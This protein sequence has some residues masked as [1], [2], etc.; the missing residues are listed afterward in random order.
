MLSE[1]KMSKKHK[2]DQNFLSRIIDTVDV[3]VIVINQQ[4]NIVLVNKACERFFGYTR[5]ELIR[6][7]VW[8][9]LLQSQEQAT[10][11]EMFTNIQAG[12]SPFQYA[13]RW[14]TR[15]GVQKSIA[16]SSS[17]I[18]DEVQTT[19]QYIVAI[20]LDITDQKNIEKLLERERILL[21][22]LI[23]SIPDLVFYKDVNSVYLDWNKAFNAFRRSAIDHEMG[24]YTDFDFYPVELALQFLE[25]D[26]QVLERRQAV[27]YENWTIN[28][29]NQ[30]VLLETKKNPYYGPDGE[31]LG[32]IGVGRDIT[33]HRLAE[34]A[35][36]TANLEIEQLICSLQSILIAITLDF[37]ITRWNPAAQRALGI[38]TPLPLGTPLNSLNIEWEWKIIAAGIDQCHQE[39]HPIYLDPLHFRRMDGYE[40]FLG[41]NISPIFDF[42]NDLA[43]FILLGADISEKIVLEARLKQA[44]KLESIGHLAAGIAHEINTPIQ[45]IGDNT[46]FLQQNFAVLIDGIS[47]LKK[48]SNTAHREQLAPNSLAELEGELQKIDIPY[49]LEEVPVAISQT[50]EGIHRVTE[51]VQA[52]KGF[53]YP[54]S[55][56]MTAIDINKALQ[57]TI[58]VARNEWKYIADIITNY[59]LHLPSVNCLLGEIN[60]V[61]LNIIVNAA[62]A[63]QN[64]NGDDSQQKGI[65]SI[66]TLQVGNWV[67]IRIS[68][69][70][71]GIPDK[72]RDH[73]F[74]PF[75]TTKEVGKG[76][77]QG[78]AIAYDIVVV[79]HGGTLTFETRMGEGSTFIVRLP[80]EP[81][82]RDVLIASD[83]VVT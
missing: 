73:I 69:T 4:G 67:E 15:D 76:T 38:P 11:Q 72:I 70:G 39:L 37:H 21:R 36:R 61:F 1:E 27:T 65:I 83:N 14:L 40:G 35:L 6:N 58:I 42:E 80:I 63:I 79:K 29:D 26:H 41:L 20:G 7:R 17:F 47:R 22:G 55:K 19:I 32:V 12:L 57:D 46:R 66:K 16:W 24:T 62:D 71:T 59:D 33:K 2:V 5:E 45:Y 10:I 50:L 77:G 53:S 74:E 78:L 30:P 44:Q 3:L 81:T 51:I 13:N 31:V 18:L 75:F 34:N 68:D 56:R 54:T 28:A 82:S 48:V 23:D 64:A 8:N 9:L 52:M 60:Q 43:G 49:L 25:Y